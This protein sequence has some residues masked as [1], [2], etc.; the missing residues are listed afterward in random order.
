MDLDPF[1]HQQD[2]NP[3]DNLESIKHDL[4]D[5][6]PIPTTIESEIILPE[7][8]TRED[9]D[10]SS[11][12]LPLA[13]E[14]LEMEV[15][16]EI[17]HHILEEL[18]PSDLTTLSNGHE[19]EEEEIPLTFTSIDEESTPT[20]ETLNDF[21]DSK[22]HDTIAATTVLHSVDSILNLPTVTDHE[23]QICLVVFL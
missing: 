3:Q 8:V 14:H 21:I 23:V 20:I 9:E 7:I 17:L 11:I 5:L 6:Y 4:E 19:D 12:S 15:R 10:L 13:V 18:S 22:E 1:G 2:N 16:E